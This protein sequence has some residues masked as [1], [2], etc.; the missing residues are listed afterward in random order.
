MKVTSTIVVVLTSMLIVSILIASSHAVSATKYNKK[1]VAS[2]Q[3]NYCGNGGE[4]RLN[5][6]CPNTVVQSQ[7]N[8]DR[9]AITDQ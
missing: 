9:S 5:I 8:E 4:A 3:N 2:T 7:G 1:S 6:Q